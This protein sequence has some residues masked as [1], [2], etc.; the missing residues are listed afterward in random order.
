MQPGSIDY[1]LLSGGN[2]AI[3]LL[4]PNPPSP[5]GGYS[6]ALQ[7]G[8]PPQAGTASIQQT[9]VV[10]TGANSILIQSGTYPYYPST[11]VSFGLDIN[12]QPIHIA[13]LGTANNLW[14]YGASIS[15]FAGSSVSLEFYSLA[16]VSSGNFYLNDISFSTQGVPE[17]TNIALFGITGLA[18]AM[19]FRRKRP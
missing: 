15:Q 10:P 3:A 5:G 11:I 2:S 13:P 7:G 6:I 19:K 17:P 1:N 4:G 14:L 16:G 9:G 18:L 8:T 12:G